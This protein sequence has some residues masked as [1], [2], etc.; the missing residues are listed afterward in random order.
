MDHMFQQGFF[1][2]KAPMFMDIVTFIVAA[3]PLLIVSGIYLAKMQMYKL[4]ALAQNVIFLVSLV[5]VGYFE[6]GVRMGGGF[7]AFIEGTGVSHSYVSAV[8]VVHIII[9]IVTLFLW[10]KTLLHA[11]KAFK[12]GYIPGQGAAQHRKDALKTFVGIVFT[13]FSG[14]WVYL[15]LFIY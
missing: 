9:A 1:G 10:I 5:V 3:L 14:I 8:L 6:I 13:S 11:N 4:H 15:L 2:T 12:K 7:N